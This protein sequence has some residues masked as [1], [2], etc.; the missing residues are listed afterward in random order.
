M[1]KQE[2]PMPDLKRAFPPMPEASH[3]ALM[4]TARSVKEDIPVKKSSIRTAALAVALIL[5]SVAAAL[6]A[7]ELGLINFNLSGRLPDAALEQMAKT[8]AANYAVG[9]IQMSLRELLA[10]GRV[11]VMTTQA[12]LADGSPAILVDRSADP[13]DPLPVAQA[14]GL[15]L[16][17]GI[18]FVEAARQSKQPLYLISTWLDMD[19]AF[20][21]GEEAA[22]SFYGE[23]GAMLQFAMIQTNPAAVQDSLP[24]T[25]NF[26]VQG[27]DPQSGAPLADGEW[28]LAET[29]TIPVSGVTAQKT[30]KPQGDAMLDGYQVISLKAEQTIAGIYLTTQAEAGPEAKQEEVYSK[31]YAWQ[32]ADGDGQP[33]VGGISM[34][35]SLDQQAWPQVQLHQMIGIGQLPDSL[36]LLGAQEGSS[37]TMK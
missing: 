4:H 6:A 3:Q 9:P 35:G 14:K 23:D 5:L 33:Y 13:Q 29:I 7:N 2:W 30:Y 1:N 10:D 11:V 26:H 12:H 34:S 20:Q 22:D 17:E 32:Y 27:I 19:E 36:R 28:R 16:P 15:N 8:Q 31:L 37:L 18:S 24:A 25:L 21:E